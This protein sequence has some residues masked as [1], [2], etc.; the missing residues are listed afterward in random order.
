MGCRQR[1]SGC[2]KLFTE[3]GIWWFSLPVIVGFHWLAVIGSFCLNN[4]GVCVFVCLCDF[5]FSCKTSTC[6]GVLDL[7]SRQVLFSWT[8]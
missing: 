2:D 7:T 8:F 4:L 5:F 1:G 3:S 6:H